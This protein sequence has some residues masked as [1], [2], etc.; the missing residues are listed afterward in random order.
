[1]YYL[2]LL[3]PHTSSV[4][5]ILFQE[6]DHSDFLSAGLYITVYDGFIYG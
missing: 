1:M 4:E 5:I 3:L 2:S 6:L